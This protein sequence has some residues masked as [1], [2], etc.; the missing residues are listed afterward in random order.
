VIVVRVG[1]V[2]AGVLVVLGTLS[3]LVRTLVVPR[4]LRSKLTSTV[5]RTVH[6]G[7]ARVAARIP[8]YE[9]KD[10][11]LAAEAPAVLLG[12]LA[13][14]LVLL[15]LGFGLVLRGV[16]PELDLAGAFREAG[17]ALFTLGFATTP[18]PGATAI[19]FVAAATGLVVVALQIA[20]LPTLYGAVN[21]REVLVTMLDARAGA[22][23][24]GPEILAR[25]QSVG[26]VESLPSLYYEWEKWAA[27]IAESHSSYPILTVFRSPRPLH[28]WVIGLLAVLDS[29]ALYQALA[30]DDA[31]TQ[32]RLCLRMGFTAL[33]DVADAI[34]LPYDP[35]PLPSAGIQLTYEEFLEGCERLA[36]VN[37]GPFPTQR[38]PE[39]AWPHFAG[40]RVNYESLAYAL[41]DVTNAVP[42]KWSGERLRMGDAMPPRAPVNRTP[43]NP[44]GEPPARRTRTPRV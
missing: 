16:S 9:S 15:V 4:G 20:Y 11:V 13:T 3:S 23:A 8:S 37:N 27:E 44:D 36:K 12:L 7:F 42:A 33:R 5:E 2:L 25:A 39:E 10:R 19:D 30:P 6:R 43:E 24:W 14:W 32:S 38:T 1:C 22:P 34:R 31:P 41:A 29:A 17:S 18:S 28:S 21:R 35:D 26:L 40:W